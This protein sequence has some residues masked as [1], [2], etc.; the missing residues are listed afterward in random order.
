[1][2]NIKNFKLTKKRYQL[3]EDWMYKFLC[4]KFADSFCLMSESSVESMFEFIKQEMDA[5]WEKIKK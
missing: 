2:H 1:M 5:E 4:G 3:I